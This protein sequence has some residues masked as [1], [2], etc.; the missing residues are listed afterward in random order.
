MS[1]VLISRNYLKDLSNSKNPVIL[2]TKRS[3]MSSINVEIFDID[4]RL[5]LNVEE[6]IENYLTETFSL[7]DEKKTKF[8]IVLD[9]NN[10]IWYKV[11]KDGYVETLSGMFEMSRAERNA[12]TSVIENY[13]D[14]AQYLSI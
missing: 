10:S 1:S 2:I 4:K 7:Y 3:D 8:I 11:E 14:L 12:V 5:Y 6:F 13:P 9:V